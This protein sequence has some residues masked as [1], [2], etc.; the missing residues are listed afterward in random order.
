MKTLLGFR[1]ADG[2]DVSVLGHATAY[3]GCGL[4]GEEACTVTCWCGL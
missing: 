2:S 1:G 4:K 3:Y